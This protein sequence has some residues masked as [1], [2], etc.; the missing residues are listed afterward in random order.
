MNTA[1]LATIPRRLRGGHRRTRR[2]SPMPS[3]DHWGDPGVR[4]DHST[5]RS[6]HL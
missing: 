3:R 1:S 5:F 6:P 2:R 4:Q